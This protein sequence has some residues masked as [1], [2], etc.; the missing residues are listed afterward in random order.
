MHSGTLF[1][2]V[3][4]DVHES[5]PGRGLEYKVE[6]TNISY[7]DSRARMGIISISKFTNAKRLEDLKDAVMLGAEAYKVNVMR[8]YFYFN[9]NSSIVLRT[10]H[11]NRYCKMIPD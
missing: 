4:L 1:L 10:I 5:P 7:E 3:D 9:S 11:C 8:I 2:T 6:L